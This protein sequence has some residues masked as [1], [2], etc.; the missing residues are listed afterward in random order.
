MVS[1]SP[2]FS[3]R[4]ALVFLLSLLGTWWLLTLFNTGPQLFHPA[5]ASLARWKYEFPRDA[6]NYGLTPQQ[7]DAAFPG[8]FGDIA[9]SVASRQ[10]NPVRLDELNIQEDH[11]LVRVLIYDAEVSR[12]IIGQIV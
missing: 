11:C 7:C 2:P 3:F 12:Y 10:G 1:L 9:T 5:S 8:F 4:T 6:A